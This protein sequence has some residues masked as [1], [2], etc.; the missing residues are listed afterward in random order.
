MST[1]RRVPIPI[2]EIIVGLQC[3]GS[4]GLSGVTAN[5]ALGAAVDILASAGGT[6]ILSETSEIYGAEHLLRSRAVNNE[7]AAR[8]DGLISWWENYAAMHGASLDNN[9]SPGNKRGGL[10][11]I[12]EKSLG[13]VAKGGRSPLTAVYNYAERVTGSGLV[14]MDTPGYD[15][16]SATGQVAGGANVIA[17]T[18]GRGSC[19]GCRPTPSIKLTSNTAL[20][21]AMEEDM[22]IDCGVIASGEATIA[23]LGREIFELIIATASGRKTKSELFG[24]GDNEFVPWHLGATL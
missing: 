21:R 23:G 10:T 9:P 15:P 14:F 24:Y 19:F 3:G 17:F 16:V 4:D 18:T 5:P 20:Y 1:A 22:D 7:V 8:L 11:T 2:S 12:L 6:A 13:A